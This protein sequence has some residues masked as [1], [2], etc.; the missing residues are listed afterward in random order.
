MPNYLTTWLRRSERHRTL[1]NLLKLDDHLLRD[2]GLT[3]S[4]VTMM[5]AGRRSIGHE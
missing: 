3:R 5:R 4:D 2:I 1:N